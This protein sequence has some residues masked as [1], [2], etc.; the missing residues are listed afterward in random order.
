MHDTA[1]SVGRDFY[2]GIPLTPAGQSPR[3][4]IVV[5]TPSSTATYAIESRDGM[6]SSGTATSSSPGVV[7]I[8]NDFQVTLSGFSDRMKG[9]RVYATGS[10]PIYVL[11]VIKYNF[12]G[13]FKQLIGY[14]SYPVHPNY[15]NANVDEYIYY[16]LSTDYAGDSE[17]TNR[18]S[19]ILLVGN[20]NGTSIIITPTQTVTL[21]ED[22]Q[23][24]STQVMVTAGTSHTVTLDRFQTLGFSSLLDLTGTKI[25]SSRPLAVISG[26]QCGQI[27]IDVNFCEPLYVHLPPTF[28]WGTHFLL[29]PFG[30]RTANQQYKY[31]TTENSTTIAYRCGT[32]AS[33]SLQVAV[34]GSGR[35]L[36]VSTPS[37]C[38]LTASSPIFLVQVSPGSMADNI[39][40]SAMSIVPHTAA[41][42]T[43]SSFFNIPNDFAISYI[44]V[45]VQAQHFTPFDIQIDGAML[46]CTWTNISNVTSDEIVGHGCTHMLAAGTHTISHSGESGVLSV[47]A[48]GWN[49]GANYG[50]AYLANLNF[51]PQEQQPTAG[52]VS[53]A[54]PGGTSGTGGTASTGGTTGTGGT[55]STDGST[56]TGGTASTGGTAAVLTTGNR[57]V[58]SHKVLLLPLL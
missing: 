55:A 53:T 51:E 1:T 13:S 38:Y 5:G 28:N 34:S 48:Y 3:Y 30:A 19:N 15:E 57:L 24:N 47:M 9:I 2:F 42:V 4:E 54:G 8:E 58:S 50:Y 23:S 49:S 33:K 16:A 44:T 39:G 21:P 18:E 27:P 46:G 10:N 29:A 32:Q 37:Y 14:E 41:H 40:D 52:T 17:I 56:G 35:L 31:V 43:S 20:H 26:H 12:F 22:A 36:S 25:V 45:T 11:V 6:I 7:L